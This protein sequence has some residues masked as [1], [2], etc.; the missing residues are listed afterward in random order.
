MHFPPNAWSWIFTASFGLAGD[1]CARNE[2]HSASR[3]CRW[4]LLEI[5]RSFVAGECR[6]HRVF[7]AARFHAGNQSN[8]VCLLVCVKISSV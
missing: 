7:G 1:I 6:N 8:F 2:L 5:F 3:N 4:P